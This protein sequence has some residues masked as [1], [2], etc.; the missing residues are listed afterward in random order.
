[1]SSRGRFQFS[2]SQALRRVAGK[3]L[4]DLSAA[5]QGGFS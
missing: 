3:R 2:F 4:S 1:M 5:P